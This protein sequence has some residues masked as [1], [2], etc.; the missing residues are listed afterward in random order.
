[1]FGG[2]DDRDK[3]RSK[4]WKSSLA[5]PPLAALYFTWCH[6]SRRKI[7][8]FSLLATFMTGRNLFKWLRRSPSCPLTSY[9]TI[10]SRNYGYLSRNYST[11]PI[12]L[13]TTSAQKQ[14]IYALSTPPG[15][16]G[17]AIVRVSGP[18]ALSVW[19]SM[20]RTHRKSDKPPIPW[21]LQR[22]RVVHPQ[23]ESLI[24]DGL[25]VYFKGTF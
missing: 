3:G 24:D 20:V 12:T 13:P 15:K 10:C 21:R 6:H 9:T 18:D 8:R 25:A 23:N 14:T 19:K 7:T 2:G 5:S 11:A 16:G 22:C 4:R 17:V 1:M